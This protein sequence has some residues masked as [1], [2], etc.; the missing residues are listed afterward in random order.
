M[1]DR[2]HDWKRVV[3]RKPLYRCAHCGARQNIPRAEEE[4]RAPDCPGEPSGEAMLLAVELIEFVM[5]NPNLSSTYVTSALVD[6]RN[7]Q[8]W[9]RVQSECGDA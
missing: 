9:L 6:L 2:D 4:A 5:R 3:A 7:V 1:S 8:R